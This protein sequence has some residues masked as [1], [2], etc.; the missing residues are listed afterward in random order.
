MALAQAG[1]QRQRQRALRPLNVLQRGAVDAEERRATIAR[2]EEELAS[3]QQDLPTALRHRELYFR[4]SLVGHCNLRCPF[5]HNEGAPTHGIAELPFLTQALHAAANVGF[6][7][8]QYTGGEPLLHPRVDECVARA[9]R[10]FPDVGITTN[11]ALLSKRL[12]GLVE[13]G[14]TRIH[15]SLQEQELQRWGSSLRWGI[16]PWLSPLLTLGRDGVLSVR[17]NLPIPASSLKSAFDFLRRLASFGCDVKVFAILPEGLTKSQPYPIEL[18]RD[19]V[20]E[21]NRRR[22]LQSERGTILLRAYHEPSGLRCAT[23]DERARCQESSRSLRL[24]ADKILRPC[25]AT[26]HWDTQLTETNMPQ[27]IRDAALLAIDYTWPVI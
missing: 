9:R 1:T 2:I 19:A 25:L 15:V 8:V 6:T 18:L 17:L 14:L 21:E 3:R 23:C 11:G 10:I 12:P 24:G 7:R 20:T 27:Q 16:P 13:V 26:R 22:N 5:C 4:V